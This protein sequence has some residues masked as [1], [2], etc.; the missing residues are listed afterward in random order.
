MFL[1]TMTSHLLAFL[2]IKSGL[3]E[4]YGEQSKSIVSGDACSKCVIRWIN[5]WIAF[6]VTDHILIT[7]VRRD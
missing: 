4:E 3:K 6:L 1:L 7:G 2:C 5:V